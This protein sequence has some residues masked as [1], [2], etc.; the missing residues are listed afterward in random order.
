MRREEKRRGSVEARKWIEGKGR[1]ETTKKTRKEK[2]QQ[3]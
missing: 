2:R 3:D 1:K